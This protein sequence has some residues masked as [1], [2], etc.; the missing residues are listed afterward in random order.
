MNA[1]EYIL[2]KISIKECDE[3]HPSGG[4]CGICFWKGVTI[5]PVPECSECK[6]DTD[7]FGRLVKENPKAKNYEFDPECFRACIWWDWFHN[8]RK[9]KCSCLCKDICSCGKI[10]YG[11]KKKVVKELVKEMK[12]LKV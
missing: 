4:M 10:K 11:E 12:K 8:I 9:L 5:Y 1:Q 7:R 3:Q 2:K 6:E